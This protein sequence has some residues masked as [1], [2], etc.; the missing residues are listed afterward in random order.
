MSLSDSIS[1]LCVEIVQSENERSQ[2]VRQIR[3]DAK[4]VGEEARKMM[5][6]LRIER[7]KAADEMRK[8][9]QSERARI[10][11][12]TSGLLKGF[13][14]ERDETRNELLKTR[15]ELLKAFDIWR[16]FV[17]RKKAVKPSA[18]TIS[19]EVKGVSREEAAVMV[20]PEAEAVEEPVLEDNILT[21][22][23]SS[24]DG[25]TLEEISKAFGVSRRRVDSALRMLVGE[26]KI[27]RRAGK[28]K[29]SS[30]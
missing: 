15:N 19:P 20:Q 3:E 7:M 24:E 17:G 4:Q 1:T 25:L 2:S 27:E 6:E 16:K 18:P 21:A 13:R 29:V 30:S 11:K 8:L 26:G 10:A 23:R 12:E 5:S 9:L 14:K 22:M 28:Y